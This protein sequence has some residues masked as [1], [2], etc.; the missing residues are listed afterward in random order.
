MIRFYLTVGLLA[1]SLTGE[2]YG[3]TRELNQSELRRASITGK[4][5]GLKRAIDSVAASVGGTA[6]EARAFKSDDV[7]YRILVKKPTGRIVSV[8]VNA[9]TGTLVSNK[10]SV[11]RQISAAAKS[12]PS[13]L[14]RSNRNLGKGKNSGNGGGN[15]G[16][17]SGGNSGGNGGGNSGGN[18]G[19]N[20]GGNGGG[21][22]GGNGGGNSGGNSGGN[23]GGNSGGNG[24]GNGGGKK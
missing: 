18:G 4:T 14:S 9:R 23:G 7:F 8:I 1:F 17:N 21:N 15:S 2:A 12:S 5:I 3:A 10:S 22:S 19:G 13:K 6:V 16:S 11:G 24:G 20:S